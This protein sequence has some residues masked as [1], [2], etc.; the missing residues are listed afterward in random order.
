VNISRR[1]LENNHIE[2]AHH[3]LELDLKIKKL[4]ILVNGLEDA[5]LG[6]DA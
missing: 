6:V 5:K 1:A 2:L 4:N 3:A